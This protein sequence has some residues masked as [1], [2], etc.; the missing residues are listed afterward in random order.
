M[1]IKKSEAKY[2]TTITYTITSIYFVYTFTFIIVKT[3]NKRVT[4]KIT[5]LHQMHEIIVPH[6]LGKQVDGQYF[7]VYFWRWDNTFL[8]LNHL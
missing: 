1:Y 4:K 7:R 6:I 8:A 3:W 2:V 5:F